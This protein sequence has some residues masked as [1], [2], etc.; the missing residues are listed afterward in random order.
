[1]SDAPQIPALVKP[2][3]MW[4]KADVE[5]LPVMLPE[6]LAKASPAITAAKKNWG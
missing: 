5:F 3:F 1:M 6:D 2:I 4:L